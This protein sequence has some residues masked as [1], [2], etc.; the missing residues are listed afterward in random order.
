M[1]PLILP[2]RGA[3]RIIMSNIGLVLVL[4]SFLHVVDRDG[5]TRKKRT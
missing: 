2:A 3:S 1:A 5:K 4:S